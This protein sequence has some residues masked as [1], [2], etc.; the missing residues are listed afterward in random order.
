MKRVTDHP[1]QLQHRPHQLLFAAAPVDLHAYLSTFST[2]L[3]K[4]KIIRGALISIPVSGIGI[5]YSSSTPKIRANARPNKTRSQNFKTMIKAVN[6]GL[7]MQHSGD[8]VDFLY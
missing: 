5:E 1:D 7:N 6:K 8:G 3:K 4:K 2:D